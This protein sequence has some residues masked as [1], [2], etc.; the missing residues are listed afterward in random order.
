MPSFLF[1][2]SLSGSGNRTVMAPIRRYA[3]KTA[4]SPSLSVFLWTEMHLTAVPMV[5]K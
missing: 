1:K 4:E 2:T 5:L 3:L